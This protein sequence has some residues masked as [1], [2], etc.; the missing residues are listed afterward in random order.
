MSEFGVLEHVS[1]D[2][3][4]ILEAPILAHAGGR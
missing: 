1:G 4:G 2:G 3:R